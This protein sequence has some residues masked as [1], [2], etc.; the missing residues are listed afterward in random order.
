MTA[1]RA[2][3]E[4]ADRNVVFRSAPEPVITG[5]LSSPQPGRIRYPSDKGKIRAS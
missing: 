1:L 3:A 5:P 2:K 4:A